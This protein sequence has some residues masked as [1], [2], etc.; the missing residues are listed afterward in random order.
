MTPTRSVLVVDD[1]ADTREMLSM[2]LEV[3]G[4]GVLL[5]E[6]GRDALDLV[7]HSRPRRDPAHQ[8]STRI[9]SLAGTLAQLGEATDATARIKA[10]CANGFVTCAAKPAANVRA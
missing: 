4:Y 9:R 7:A 10:S 6:S 5:A 2:A 1:Y 3:A 8:W